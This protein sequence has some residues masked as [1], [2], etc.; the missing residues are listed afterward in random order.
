MLRNPDQ[1]EKPVVP[2]DTQSVLVP[3]RYHHQLPK[4]PGSLASAYPKLSIRSMT[5][6]ASKGLES[7][8]V[9]IL[10]ATSERMGFPSEIVD[11]PVLNLVLPEPEPFGHAEERRLFYVALTRARR[12]VTILA[13]RENP[14][15][16]VHELLEQPEYETVPVGE[17]NVPVRRCSM[18]GGRMLAR[19]SR[20]GR[21]RF[22]CEHRRLC[23][24][25]LP[26][27]GA[28]GN[29]IPVS[30]AA[31]S[32]RVVC[33]CGAEYA[34][35]PECSDGWLVERTGPYG[36]FLGCSLYPECDGKGSA[37]TAGPYGHTM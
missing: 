13:D 14:S 32:R 9:V 20:D 16:F 7:D 12:T 11:D 3:A 35:C 36:R 18:C 4:P 30:A 19:P 22:E 34:A 29:D 8:H 6:P 21:L 28:C 1:I 26:A 27:C 5:V 10:H 24:H 25:S 33:S 2:A 37:A 31:G 15:P 23:G 17:Q